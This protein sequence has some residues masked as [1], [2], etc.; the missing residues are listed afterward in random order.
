MLKMSKLK[1]SGTLKEQRERKDSDQLPSCKRRK[2]LLV[3]V[4][5]NAAAWKS[6]KLKFGQ[7]NNLPHPLP[8]FMPERN[9]GVQPPL[10][11]RWIRDLKS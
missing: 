10:L 3:R 5:G 2:T 7:P 9:P 4:S 6:E 8:N 11:G 1:S